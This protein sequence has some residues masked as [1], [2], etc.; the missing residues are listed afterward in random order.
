M[1][2]DQQ[3]LRELQLTSEITRL[4]NEILHVRSCALSRP[5]TPSDIHHQDL[6]TY[7]G[8]TCR[9]ISITTKLLVYFNRQQVCSYINTTDSMLKEKQKRAEA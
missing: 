1:K 6:G 7:T 5:H 8:V 2:K 3:Q 9:A 4:V